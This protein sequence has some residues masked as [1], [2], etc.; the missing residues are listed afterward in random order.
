MAMAALNGSALFW[1]VNAGIF[2][3]LT[4]PATTGNISRWT[5]WTGDD[6]YLVGCNF[7]DSF[8]VYERSGS[9]LTYLN[10]FSTF[11]ADEF[12]LSGLV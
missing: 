1:S 8:A 6:K 2:T 4:S 3:A 10:K 5:K 9:T 11:A 12:S 7:G